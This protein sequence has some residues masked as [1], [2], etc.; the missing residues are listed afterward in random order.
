MLNVRFLRGTYA[1][2]SALA[3]KDAATFYFCTDT[4]QLFLG[5]VELDSKDVDFK[6]EASAATDGKVNVITGFEIVDGKIKSGSVAE[7]LLAKVAVTGAA[8]DVAITDAD[9]KFT[10]TD[11]E[12]ALAE[13]AAAFEAGGIASKV[14]VEES[15]ASGDTFKSFAFY[16][17]VKP[18]DDAAAK[19]AKKITT[20]NIPKDYLVRSAEVKV[21]ETADTPYTG[22][23]VGDKYIDF[24][25]NTKDG[26]GTGT[27]V[28]LYIAV[29]DLIHPISGSTGSEVTIAV[30][31][32]NE[33]SA[34]INTIDGA[35]IIYKAD[36]ETVKAALTRL[37]GA[38][39]VT[40][41]VAK[42]IKDAI[43]GLDADV[44]AVTDAAIVDTEKVAVVTGVTEVDGVIT[45]VDSIDVDKAG[46]ASRA[47]AAVIGTSSDP[48]TADTINGVKN[49]IGTIVDSLDSTA[50]IAS[51]SGNVVTLKGGLVETEGVVTNDST[52]TDITLEEVAVTG[53]A[54]DVSVADTGN[55]YTGTTV[56]AVLAEIGT[57]LTWGSI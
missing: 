25:I 50:A 23:V 35:K 51:Q 17:G 41:S 11:V 44:N 48:S 37:D 8:A 13:L 40:G 15:G 56:E 10:A 3:T 52:A 36:G 4:E 55:N 18:A 5:E 39:T 1:S 57:A 34:T 9:S 31:A 29:N 33:I 43:G 46:A 2:Y 7:Q 22:A 53:A 49:L 45:G 14:T 24:T 16:Q 30:N 6:V 54:A 12:G 27:A 21:V 28:H 38:D 20:I 19:E 32:T 26:D 47:K 42:K